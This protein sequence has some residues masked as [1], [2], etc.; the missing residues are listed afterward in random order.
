M[1]EAWAPE[2]YYV[3]RAGTWEQGAGCGRHYHLLRPVVPASSFLLYTERKKEVVLATKCCS[4]LGGFRGWNDI[5]PLSSHSPYVGPCGV[6][7]PHASLWALGQFAGVLPERLWEGQFGIVAI[8]LNLEMKDLN[9]APFLPLSRFSDICPGTTP[10]CK[11]EVLKAS[12]KM[13]IKSIFKLDI[14]C[15]CQELLPLEVAAWNS[16]ASVL[17]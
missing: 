2:E 8:A 13:C 17:S 15:K 3:L 9:S 6:V 11:V 1:E 14:L 5:L 7:R 4:L 16:T 12:C 10:T